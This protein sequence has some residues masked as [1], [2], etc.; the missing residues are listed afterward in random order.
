MRHATREEWAKRVEGWRRSRLSAADYAAKVGVNPRSLAWWKWQLESTSTARKTARS[1]KPRRSLSPLTFVEVAPP[2]MTSGLEVVA[3]SGMC[4]RVP[5]DFDP[6]VL[7]R[8]LDVLEHR[9]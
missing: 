8:L 3:P 2:R 4:I 7:G 9:K 1:R 5:E 6:V